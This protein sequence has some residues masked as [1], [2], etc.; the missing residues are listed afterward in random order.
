MGASDTQQPEAPIRAIIADD[1]ALARRAVR[2]ALQAGGITVIAEASDGQEA[3]ELSRHYR[4]DV[5]L[6][7]VVMPGV[8]GLRAART[9]ACELPSCKVLMITSTEDDELGILSLRAGAAG[10]LGKTVSPDTLPRAVR[11]LARGE[12]VVSRQLT[13]RLINDV[14][15]H[16]DDGAGLRPVRSPLSR[17]EWEVLDYLCEGWSTERIADHLVLSI[18]TVR[19]HVKSILRKLG[20]RTRREA[21]EATR[22]M[23]SSL[24][25]ESSSEPV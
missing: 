1:D 18:E 17:R 21:V 10:F 8:D 13:Q 11:A 9:L 5:V 15:S 12:P 2:D 22:K 19:T 7:D 14:R 16:R 23:R 4:P 25:S 3:I 24:I 6:M 20:V